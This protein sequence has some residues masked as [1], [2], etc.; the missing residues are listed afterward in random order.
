MKSFARLSL[1]FVLLV[2]VATTTSLRA[3]DPV[4][5]LDLGPFRTPIG[6]GYFEIQRV[7]DD[8]HLSEVQ[9]AAIKR[10]REHEARKFVEELAAAPRVATTE[11]I[12]LEKELDTGRGKRIEQELGSIL[13]EKQFSRAGQLAVQRSGAS[14]LAS[15]PVARMVEL[16]EEQRNAIQ[17]LTDR[18]E[19]ETSNLRLEHSDMKQDEIAKR[20]QRISDACRARITELLTPVQRRK[21]DEIQGAKL[22]LTNRELRSAEEGFIAILRTIPNPFANREGHD[23]VPHK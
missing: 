12:K 2:S 22:T 7:R 4:R 23:S 18:A 10:L 14:A 17:D 1:I 15:T 8:L 5:K 21:F 13:D 11:S 9:L 6:L 20:S 19:K 3:S 16:T